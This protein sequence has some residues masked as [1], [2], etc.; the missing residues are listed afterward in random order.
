MGRE[1]ILGLSFT[2]PDY[3]LILFRFQDGAI[4]G[5]RPVINHFVMILWK[6]QAIFL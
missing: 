4:Y 2:S 6:Y 1:E 3:C 5:K